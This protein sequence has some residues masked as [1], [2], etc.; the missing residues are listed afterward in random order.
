MNPFVCMVA[1]F[2]FSRLQVRGFAL[3]SATTSESVAVF[4]GH[5][6]SGRSSGCS[7]EPGSGPHP[8]WVPQA[9]AARMKGET[10]EDK[11]LTCRGGSALSDS[12]E[13]GTTWLFHR[14]LAI[15]TVKLCFVRR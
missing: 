6:C 4:F 2:R 10:R 15:L 14:R 13:G 12:V 3:W 5:V 9:E 1:L 11:D 7:V 8:V